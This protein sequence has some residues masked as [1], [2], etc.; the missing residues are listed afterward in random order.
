MLH[1]QTS[2][3]MANAGRYSK[4]KRNQVN[5]YEVVSDVE[6]VDSEIEGEDIDSCSQPKVR[7]CAL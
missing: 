1:A 5:Y 3:D 4:R 6:D 7:F 2:Q